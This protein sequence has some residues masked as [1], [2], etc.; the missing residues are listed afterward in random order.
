MT[1]T[2]TGTASSVTASKRSSVDA[3]RRLERS[4]PSGIQKP[5]NYLM[6][7]TQID[8]CSEGIGCPSDSGN[9]LSDIL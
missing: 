7:M 9:Q 5:P 8:L 3:L 6:K 4:E 2:L 1:I